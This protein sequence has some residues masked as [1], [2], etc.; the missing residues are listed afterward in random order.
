MGREQEEEGQDQVQAKEQ[1]LKQGEN[2]VG[3]SGV[4]RMRAGA[5]EVEREVEPEDGADKTKI[6]M[7]EE[8]QPTRKGS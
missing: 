7:R 6:C 3:D 4:K 1:P 8:P 5:R 2:S